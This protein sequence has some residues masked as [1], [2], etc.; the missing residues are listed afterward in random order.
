MIRR[1]FRYYYLKTVRTSGSAE[2]IARG[3]GLGVFLGLVVPPP[4]Q[5]LLAIPV[6]F[7]GRANRPVT[8]I[9]TFI[10]NPLTVPLIY[11]G[12]WIL[13]NLFLRDAGEPYVKSISVSAIWHELWDQHII[14]RDLQ[15]LAIGAVLTG[16]VLAAAAY[17]LTLWGVRRYRA[18]R[19][20]SRHAAAQRR[21]SPAEFE[22]KP[23]RH[24]EGER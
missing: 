20:A 12:Q 9:A 10:Y 3:A 23:Q 4:F 24:Q 16:A 19:L 22:P 17:G 18:R 13:G 1:P 14:G 8:L 6:A 11:P 5:L 21:A 15:A 7:L 2:Q